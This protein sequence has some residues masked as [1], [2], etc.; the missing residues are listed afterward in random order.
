MRAILITATICLLLGGAAVDAAWAETSAP[1][2]LT[3]QKLVLYTDLDG[4]EIDRLPALFDQAFPQWLHYFK[5]DERKLSDF[6][7]T[8][9]LMKDKALFTAAGLFPADLPPFPH[10]YSRGR[11]LWLYEQP[12]EYYR[13]HL[14][15]HEGVHVFMIAALGGCGPPWYMEGTAE[16]LATHRI[17]DG[18][19]EVG[20][21]PRSRDEAPGWGRVRVIRDAAAEDRAL[22]LDDVLALSDTAHRQN[23]PYAWC[24]AAVALLDRNPRYRERFRRVGEF[25]RDGD[26]NQRFRKLFAAD[27]RELC[28]QWRL[29]V[30]DMEYGYDFEREAV[31]FS[32]GKML[33]AKGAE[34]AVAADRGWQN[35]GLRLRGGEKYRLTAAGRYQL[36]REPKVW[37]SEPNGVSIRYYRGLPLGVLL[38]AVRPDNPNPDEPSALQKPIVVGLGATIEPAQSGTLFLRINDSAG[39]LD[40]N[41][42][43]LRVEVRRAE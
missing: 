42:G 33:P 29:T 23:E 8:G 27:W 16:Y 26:F 9:C 39:E 4:T 41:A 18:K 12:T 36:A 19:L 25:V 13:R 10:G 34:V 2:K 5:V 14:L 20:Y 7:A 35:S 32:P 3:G 40:D 37:W 22:T 43:E 38:A 31:D 28:E 21:I 1:R 15:L 6:Q 30:A 17:K 11:R 24:W